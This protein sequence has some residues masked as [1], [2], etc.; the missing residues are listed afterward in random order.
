MEQDR[1][2]SKRKNIQDLRVD[3]AGNAEAEDPDEE[4]RPRSAGAF[5]GVESRYAYFF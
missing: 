4:E 2:V 5:L 3:D 1:R